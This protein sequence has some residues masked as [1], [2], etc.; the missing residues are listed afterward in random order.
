MHMPALVNRVKYLQ[1]LYSTSL[2]RSLFAVD[3]MSHANLALKTTVLTHVPLDE[4]RIRVIE[5]ISPWDW[6]VFVGRLR[7]AQLDGKYVD[8]L[9]RGAMIGIEVHR[10]QS[11]RCSSLGHETCGSQRS[12]RGLPSLVGCRRHPGYRP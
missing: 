10:S 8:L 12:C 1:N 9:T 2:L 11:L 7:E 3:V 6:Y 4:L 5:C